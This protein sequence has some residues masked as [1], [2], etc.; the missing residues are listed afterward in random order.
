MWNFISDSPSI[1]PVNLEIVLA[2]DEQICNNEQP[3][4]TTITS[5]ALSSSDLTAG[6]QT[7]SHTFTPEVQYSQLQ[8]YLYGTSVD[9]HD[10][11]LLNYADSRKRSIRSKATRTAGKRTPTRPMEKRATGTHIPLSGAIVGVDSFS[12]T[13]SC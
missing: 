10:Y 7:V 1:D 11:T 6:W 13:T 4:T 2:T 3:F 9:V 8:V 12:V 5:I